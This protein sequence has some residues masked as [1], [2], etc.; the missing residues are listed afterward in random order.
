MYYY[1][2]RIEQSFRNYLTVSKTLIKNL[3]NMKSWSLIVIN[4]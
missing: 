3:H 4:D 2:V 1:V